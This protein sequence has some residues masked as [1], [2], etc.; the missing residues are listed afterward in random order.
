MYS[1]MELLLP[2]LVVSLPASLLI[3]LAATALLLG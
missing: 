1:M 2:L 3:I